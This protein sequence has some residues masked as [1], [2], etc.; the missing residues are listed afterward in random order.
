M[1]KTLP[2]TANSSL[3]HV[4]PTSDTTKP[5]TFPSL[6]YTKENLSL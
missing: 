6:T 4:Q 2:E 3:Y 5:R 1:T